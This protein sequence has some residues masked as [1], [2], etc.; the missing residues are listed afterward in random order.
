MSLIAAAQFCL[1]FASS[2]VALVCQLWKRHDVC[3]TARNFQKVLN[4]L[5]AEAK[6]GYIGDDGGKGNL[7]IITPW[8]ILLIVIKFSITMYEVIMNLPYIIEYGDII[9]VESFIAFFLNLYIAQIAAVFSDIVFAIM[10]LLARYFYLLDEILKALQLEMQADGDGLTQTQAAMQIRVH[11]KKLTQV[12]RLYT[13]MKRMAS[14]FA[15]CIEVSIFVQMFNTFANLLTNLYALLDFY[16]KGN[17]LSALNLVYVVMIF[18]NICLLLHG[19]E[20]V[21]KNSEHLRDTILDLDASWGSLRSKF[22]SDVLVFSYW[23]ESIVT[24]AL[25]EEFE[26]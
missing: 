6:M 8:I 3:R 4:R 7:D 14:E 13:Q 24:K 15:R 18:S 5:S 16:V 9:N 22:R 21:K 26:D 1:G 10:L 2:F 11:Q 25:F 12:L 19:A 20:W 23:P 17:V